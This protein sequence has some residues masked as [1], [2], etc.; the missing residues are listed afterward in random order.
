VRAGDFAEGSA[1]ALDDLERDGV[2]AACRIIPLE[3]LLPHV[4]AVVLNER[5]VKRASHGNEIMSED[6]TVWGPP[7]SS[8]YKLLDGGGRLIAVAESRPG[9]LLHPVTVLV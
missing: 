7:G 2:K 1:I 6:A 4:P 9:G 8:T 5:G 3:Q